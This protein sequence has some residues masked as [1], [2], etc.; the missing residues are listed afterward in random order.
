MARRRQFGSVRRLPS[1]R[2][3]ARYETPGAVSVNAPTTYAT[4]AEATAWLATVEADQARGAWLDP[5]AGRLTLAEYATS[6]LQGHVR[7]AKRTKEIYEAQLRLH[8]LPEINEA[9]PAL[10]GIALAD[11][12]PVLIRRWYGALTEVRGASSAAKAYVRLRQILTQAVNDERITKNPCRIDRGGVEHHPEQLFTT[13]AELYA[14][15]DAVPPSY[16]A[17]ILTAGLAGL[18]AGELF[19]LRRSDVDLASGVITVRRKRLRLASGETI[20]DAPKSSAG[21]RTVALPAVLVRE[22]EHHLAIHTGGSD[23]EAHVFSSPVGEPIERSNF[24]Y[25][26]W[27]PATKAVGLP[28]L[29]LHDLRHTAGTLAARTGATTKELMARLGHASPRASMIYQHAADDRDRVIAE[30]L[31]EM[32]AEAGVDGLRR[33]N[34]P[35]KPDSSGTDLARP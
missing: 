29:R 22:L 14:L 8:I 9:V 1:G 2:W 17:L 25:R 24:R 28:G 16:R 7:V 5:R 6:W 34:D 30:R 4:K 32:A 35:E 18:R 31:D 3:Q 12:T 26:V 10:G 23:P 13:M 33:G 15:A 11:L 20:E 19:A 27:L 21:R